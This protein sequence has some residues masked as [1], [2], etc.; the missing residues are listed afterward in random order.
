MAVYL[1]DAAG[2]Q[3]SAP[4]GRMTGQVLQ[5]SKCTM[6]LGTSA[7]VN[8]SLKSTLCQKPAQHKHHSWR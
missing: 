1:L 5:D 4:G 6:K 8:T 3:R 7:H 2:N